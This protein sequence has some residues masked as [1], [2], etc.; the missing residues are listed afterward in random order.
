MSS[1]NLHVSNNFPVLA[2]LEHLRDADRLPPFL[3]GGVADEYSKQHGLVVPRSPAVDCLEEMLTRNHKNKKYN[4]LAPQSES[5]ST[6]LDSS[7]E[8]LDTTVQENQVLTS[9]MISKENVPFKMK[10]I[11]VIETRK[12]MDPRISVQPHKNL[13]SSTPARNEKTG[14]TSP[15]PICQVEPSGISSIHSS[16]AGGSMLVPRVEREMLTTDRVEETDESETDD[17]YDGTT[18][19]SNSNKQLVTP[20]ISTSGDKVKFHTTS[21]DPDQSHS[22]LHSL[23]KAQL[24]SLSPSTSG[25][26][27]ITSNTTGS[28]DTVTSYPTELG[29]PIPSCAAQ[30]MGKVV[31]QSSKVVLRPSTPT[32][33]PKKSTSS[34]SSVDTSSEIFSAVVHS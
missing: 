6:F 29:V 24:S 33:A 1:I 32:A 26:T 22:L 13:L 9:T 14:L 34:A 30:A 19:N 11:S 16:D 3:P 7:S 17:W 5:S 2:R 21:P 25:I 23:I 8:D 27:S 15:P 10:N 20:R 28:S 31:S 4:L 18:I 12:S